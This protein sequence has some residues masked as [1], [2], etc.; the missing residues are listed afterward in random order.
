MM[1][2]NNNQHRNVIDKGE[3]IGHHLLEGILV[4]VAFLSLK[5]NEQEYERVG[6]SVCSW[7]KDSVGFDKRIVKRVLGKLFVGNRFE[8]IVKIEG[9]ISQY[10]HNLIAPKSQLIAHECSLEIEG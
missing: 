2:T 5:M 3:L 7:F 8:D 1:G 10:I 4:K 9:E 6:G